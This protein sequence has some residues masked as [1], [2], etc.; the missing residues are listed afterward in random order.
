M[1]P[2]KPV[3]TYVK[4]RGCGKKMFRSPRSR[5]QFCPDCLKFE[6]RFDDENIP[7]AGR[8]VFWAYLRKHGRRCHLSGVSLEI[9]DFT[10]PWYLVFSRLNP[11]DKSGIVPAAALFEVMKAGLWSKDFRYYV[12]AL[13][14]HRKKHL[15]VK[16]RP[17]VH[18]RL[19]EP[20][21]LTAKGL[22]PV[23]GQPIEFK[24][25]KYCA[26]CSRLVQ[27]M[28]L[29]RFSREV[30]DAVL[31]Y[32]RKYGFVCY[33]TGMPLV[34]D[35]PKSPWY[36]VF[37][38]WNPRDPRKIVITSALVN[39]MKS[40]LTEDEFWY[41][42]RQLANFF[43]YGTPVRKRKLK[44]WSRPYQLNRRRLLKTKLARESKAV[45]HVSA[46]LPLRVAK[47]KYI[48]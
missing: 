5:V 35:D 46:G 39:R 2:N 10:G 27:R 36:L 17:L 44:F 13:D 41:F 30:I 31:D 15:K 22:C 42:I 38:H 32:L 11:G 23:C 29:A 16:K 12:L 14:D 20:P 21:T 3:R 37:D 34:L 40:D 25:H 48:V 1:K 19:P 8:K 43:R 28:R 9:D 26:R 47:Y 18:W 4:C 7:I 24:G 45:A 6:H 33:Y